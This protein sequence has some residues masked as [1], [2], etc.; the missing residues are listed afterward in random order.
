MIIIKPIIVIILITNINPPTKSA[1][2]AT[3]TAGLQPSRRVAT[4]DWLRLTNLRNPG[5]PP[6]MGG[7]GG[8]GWGLGFRV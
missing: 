2:S 7:G 8:G 6:S 3:D 5:P 1:L 4:V